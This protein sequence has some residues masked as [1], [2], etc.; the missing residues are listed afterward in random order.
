MLKTLAG[1]HPYIIKFEG[2]FE[3]TIKNTLYLI[4]EQVDGGSLEV[5]LKENKGSLKED[6]VVKYFL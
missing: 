5:K 6:E 3:D 2:I 4:M 1:S